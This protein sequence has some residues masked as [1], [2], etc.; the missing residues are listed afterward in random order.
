MHLKYSLKSLSLALFFFASCA[1][2]T[3]AQDSQFSGEIN[4]NGINLRTDATTTSV[5]LSV[6]EK[7]ER[8]EVVLEQFGWYKVR[9]PKTVAVY[10]KKKLASCI[11][12]EETQTIL[13][14]SAQA[15]ECCSAKILGDRVNI[16]SK[17]SESA[18]IV[19]IADK[20]E[21]VNVISESGGWYKIEP[22]QNSFGW[23]NK[24]FIDKA[25]L[26]PKEKNP[27]LTQNDSAASAAENSEANLVLTGVVQPYGMVFMRSATHKLVTADNK[28]YL[29]KGNRATLNGL[30]R[31][32]VKVIGKIIS[33]PGA[34]YPIIEIRIIEVAS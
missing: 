29:L 23:V 32:K 13:A 31:Q 34:K 1:G 21:I 15:K 2:F 8:V 19:G 14:P 22:I 24:K 11:K 18:P 28:I 30:N 17:P 4:S 20:N 5:I 10:V 27:R 9:L 25:P 3:Y 16:R 33:A 7:G 26:S 6:L 12:S